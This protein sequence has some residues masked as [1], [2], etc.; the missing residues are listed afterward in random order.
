LQDQLYYASSSFDVK[1]E[2]AMTQLVKLRYVLAG[3][4]IER[5]SSSLYLTNSMRSI[6][7]EL[8]QGTLFYTG[9]SVSG[10]YQG[11]ARAQ[12]SELSFLSNNAFY[13]MPQ[14]DGVAK[15][16]RFA[17]VTQD[18]MG[19]EYQLNLT[20]ELNYI[21]GVKERVSLNFSS[22]PNANSGVLYVTRGYYDLEDR[23][24][25]F[26]D[27]EHHS[28]YCDANQRSFKIN[29][30]LQLN[31]GEGLSLHTRFYSVRPITGVSIWSS[32]QK[33]G[34]RVLLAYYDSIPALC[35]AQIE[36]AQIAD[37]Q[38]FIME[39]KAKINLNSD[40]IAEL[41]ES[42]LE[43]ECADAYWNMLQ[44][45]RATWNVYFSTYGADPTQPNGGPAGN[46][47]GIRPVHVREGIAILTNIGYMISVPGYPEELA[48]F[49]G[50]I[51]GNGGVDDILDVSTIIP[52]L[53][54]RQNFRVGLCGGVY[55]LGGGATLGFHQGVFLN[56][57]RTPTSSANT[58]F[59]ELGHCMGYSHSSGMT[60]GPW[61]AE[62][63]APYYVSNIHTFPIPSPDILNSSENPNRY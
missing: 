40:E 8:P 42:D 20:S 25:I 63:S 26:Q 24:L 43:I 1:S 2:S 56:H 34:E 31:K 47:R 53:M 13:I 33:Y 17:V 62:L 57:Y 46:W 39:S 51:W 22:H 5:Q 55:G 58:I 11:A 45:I 10:L 3:V 48:K 50:K 32:K 52:A 21:A 38:T 15:A 18:H 60:Y 44:Q 9:M 14:H 19:E 59:H 49:Q 12:S 37:K 35:D 4:D 54:S 27:E 61:G 30:T 7:V 6:N 41:L 23:G 28:V 36:F 29:K 16:T